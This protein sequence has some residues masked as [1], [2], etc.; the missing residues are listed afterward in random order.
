MNLVGQKKIF[1]LEKTFIFG[2]EFFNK[3]SISVGIAV[4]KL[5]KIDCLSWKVLMA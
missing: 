5:M 4:E 1:L 3:L 2:R